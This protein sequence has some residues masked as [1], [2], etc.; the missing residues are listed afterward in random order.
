MHRTHTEYC[1]RQVNEGSTANKMKCDVGLARLRC[2]DVSFI[3]RVRAA[4]FTAFE[5]CILETATICVIR[6]TAPSIQ[7]RQ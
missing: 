4:C 3:S 7:L 2:V 1:P 6:F 5:V